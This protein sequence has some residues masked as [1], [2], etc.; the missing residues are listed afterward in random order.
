[1]RAAVRGLGRFLWNVP[2]GLQLSAIYALLLATVL[3]LLG[4]ALYSQINTFLIQ[5]TADRMVRTTRPIL[6]QPGGRGYFQYHPPNPFG[7]PRRPAL[8]IDQVAAV[9]VQ[10][11]TASDVSVAV[12]D[13]SGSVVTATTSLFTGAEAYIPPLPSGW[14]NQIMGGDNSQ[15]IGQWVLPNGSGGR[16]LVMVSPVV[17]VGDTVLPNTQLYLEQ[18]ASLEGA[19][20]ILNQLRLYVVLGTVIGTILGVIAGLALTRVVLS[21]LDRMART[22][23]AIE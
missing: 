13:D 14:Q 15:T 5:N 18:I 16:S 10:G 21:P 12:L 23:A 4:T 7:D 17:L 1:M 3:L 8:S 11:L 22:A 20:A 9:L 2:I 19:D 6:I